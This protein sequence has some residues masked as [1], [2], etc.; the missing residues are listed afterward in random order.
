[1]CALAMCAAATTEAQPSRERTQKLRVAVMDLSGSALKLQANTVNQMPPQQP[2]GQPQQQ[3]T[4]V[5]I[6]I[7]PPAEFARGLTEMLTSV[8]IKTGKFVVLERAAMQQI[9]QEQAVAT[10]GKT[11][12]ETGARQGELLGAQV[13]I[14]GDIT[15]FTYEKSAVGG[16]MS[17]VVKGL[18][19]ASEMVSAEVIIDL[20]LIDAVTGEVIHSAKGSGK[21]SAVGVAADLTRDDRSYGAD[22]MK[23]TPLGQASRQAIQKAVV[24]M[25][26]EMPKVRWF[27]RVIDV[28]NGV[29][30]VN[31]AE[32]D[33]M[34]PGLEL[35]V[36]AQQEALIDPE[37][38]KKLGAPEE[39]IGTIVIESVKEGFSTAR[40]VTP[41][42]TP[43]RGNVVRF[44]SEEKSSGR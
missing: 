37:T 44:K 40:I 33:G 1:M 9:E 28:R 14:T 5:T 11:T 34:R 26:L 41:G 17:N 27:G 3:T 39:L 20:R 6:D 36:F 12:P 13:L 16:S 4:T 23:S 25:L 10:A 42:A 24:T 31:A 2:Y 30:Y 43:A 22:A 19:V 29:V 7:P 38:G 18:S 32:A 8:L 35:E 15:G 21:A